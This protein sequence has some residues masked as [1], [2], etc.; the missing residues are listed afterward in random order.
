MGYFQSAIEKTYKK[1]GDAVIQR[2]LKAVDN[3]M[4]NL[5]KV[6]YPKE[7]W[8]SL[9]DELLPE[10]YKYIGHTEQFVEQVQ[11]KMVMLRGDDIPVSA[12]PPGGVSPM[13][14]SANE[15]KT[16]ADC[17]PEV[18]MDTCTQ[19]NYCSY[20]C[21]HA[22]IRPFLIDQNTMDKAPPTLEARKA[23]SSEQSGYFFRIQVSH[24]DC[25]GCEV[26]VTTCPDNA[27]KMTSMEDV[28]AAGHAKNW[29]FAMTVPD[30]S[31]RFDRFSVKGSQFNQPLLE[32]SGACPGCGE[33]P[34]VKLLTQ[35]LRR[36]LSPCD[37]RSCKD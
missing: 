31:A 19:C 23:T 24:Y 27:L 6:S 9:Q 17:V 14:L 5:N 20:V 2:N 25:T 37:V 35:M 28:I 26:C 10:E 21:P 11:S 18:D 13:S 29:D 4:K 32:F 16:Q 15:R 34:Y 30:R 33:T 7:T 1:H 12:F 36:I 3:S 22:V 8:A